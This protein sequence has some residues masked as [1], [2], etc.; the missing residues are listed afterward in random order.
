VVRFDDSDGVVMVE[1]YID[2]NTDPVL[3]MEYELHLVKPAPGVKELF[4][5]NLD[6]GMDYQAF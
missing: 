1:G 5:S 4:E 3:E 2:P 6:L